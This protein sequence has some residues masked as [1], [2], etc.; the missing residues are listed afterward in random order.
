MTD[1]P[2]TAARPEIHTI[3]VVDDDPTIRSCV[4][5]MLERFGYRVL[6]ARDGRE[7]V[8]IFE[9]RH[10]E[11]GLVLLDLEMPILDG[12]AALEAMRALDPDL[13]VLI[14][15]GTCTD[16]H[17]TALV[18]AGVHGFIDK[19]FDAAM[20]LREVARVLALAPPLSM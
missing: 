9:D 4:Q 19:P 16:H 6:V 18:D 12:H 5:R 13:R 8:S 15:S 14:C 3:L 2:R 17:R 7:A 20:L 11:I 1:E 10:Q